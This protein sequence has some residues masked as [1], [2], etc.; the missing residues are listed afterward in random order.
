MMEESLWRQDLTDAESLPYQL[1]HVAWAAAR[2]R[3]HERALQVWQEILRL[4]PTYQGIANAM[5][6][7]LVKL[8]RLDEAEAIFRNCLAEGRDGHHPLHNL[9]R[10]LALRGAYDE[11][12]ALLRRDVR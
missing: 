11:A 7:M 1:F 2:A 9:A 4:D 3:Q 12:V 10:V 6:Q 5:G 8:N